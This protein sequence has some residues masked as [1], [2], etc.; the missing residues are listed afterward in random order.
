MK[1]EAEQAGGAPD[2]AP[3]SDVETIALVGVAHGT[4]HFFHL[5]LPPLFPMLAADYGFSY[6]ELGLLVTVF[7]V[8]SGVGQ[9]MAGFVVD[10]IG[11][12]PVLLGAMVCFAGAALAAA[13]A[14]G[15]TGFML[16]AAL[17]GLGNAPFHPADFSILNQRVS[18]ARLGHAFSVHGISGN[19]GWAAAPLVVA[20][21]AAASGS[22]RMAMVACAV[23]A[24]AVALLLWW[25]SAALRP[26]SLARIASG[27]PSAG[28][29]APS[30]SSLSFL[31]LPSVWVCFLF[32][33]W[34][35]CSLAAVQSFL[36]PAM[37]RLYE[38]PL[39]WLAM[40]VTG[41]MLASAGGMVVGGFVVKSSPQL[42]RNIAW[43]LSAA[44]LMLLLA[45]SGW[46][47]AVAS[48]VLVALAGA[49]VGLAGPSRDMLIRQAAP[50]GATGRVYGAVYSGLDVG[51]AVAAPV[52]GWLLDRGLSSS[53]FA[54]AALALLLGVASAAWV[55]QRLPGRAVALS[56]EGAG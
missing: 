53:V 55:G 14:Q 42:E 39:G 13:G 3:P 49:G 51:F 9:A 17:A 19:L 7:F 18:P 50:P 28:T 8:I 45:G 15:Y 32:F 40:M 38:Q 36:G 6:A 34:S 31:R 1:P 33:F 26:R 2:H 11:G 46:L 10:R 30:E 41:Y 24:L 12:W 23:W 52:F 22:W 56:S 27:P 4:S 48:G 54:G 37:G 16:A 5:L 29:P 21:V 43:A 47:P 20:G 35:T 25:R 44:A